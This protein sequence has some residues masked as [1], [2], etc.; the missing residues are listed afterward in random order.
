[1][2]HAEHSNPYAVVLHRHV[3]EKSL[4][5]GQLETA[6]SNRSVARCQSPKAVFV[7]HPEAN[8]QEIAQAVEQIYQ[9]KKVKVVKV[10]VIHVKPKQR[11]VRGR[12]GLRPGYK[13]AIVTF[14]PGDR[15]E[16]I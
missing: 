6:K 1:M 14:E 2:K 4:V 8:K 15:I 13:K 11:R 9:D 12:P 7:V 3:T 16:E 5:L 10:N